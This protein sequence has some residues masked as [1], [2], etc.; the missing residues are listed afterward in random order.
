MNPVV[1]WEH[2][3]KDAPALGRFYSELFGWRLEPMPEVGYVLIDT[4][5]GSGANGGI[6]TVSDGARRPLFYVEVDDL[7]PALDSI[8]TAG[9]TMTLAPLTEVVTFAQVADPEGNIV[10]LLKHGDRSPV[11]TG[12]APLS[13][14][15]TSPQRP[16]RPLQTST[17]ASSDGM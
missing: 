13:P 8:Q 4:C 1:H 12:D 2:F 10:G 15:S 5:A 7:Q 14:D 17:A 11:S 9:G 6:A 16:L 3:A